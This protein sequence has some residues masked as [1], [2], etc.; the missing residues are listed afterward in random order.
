[1]YGAFGSWGI[2]SGGAQA[3]DFEILPLMGVIRI[4]TEGNVRVFGVLMALIVPF[5]LLPTVWGLWRCWQDVS[6]RRWTPLT[7]LLLFS[8]AI[9][10]FVPFST[11]REPL[12]ILRFIGGLQVAL[13]LYS[14]ERRQR[15]ALRY[16]SFW[17]LTTLVLLV[18]DV[19]SLG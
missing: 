17:A 2:G 8:A 5:V 4:L 11:Y 12:G 10:L 13:I 3:T 7:T 19:S 14:A 9:M 15:R 6:S 1:L 16:C 18:S